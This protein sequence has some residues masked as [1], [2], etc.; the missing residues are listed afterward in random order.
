LIGIGPMKL[1]RPLRKWKRK[2]TE[3]K[4]KKAESDKALAVLKENENELYFNNIIL[5]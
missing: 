4:L 3:L 2:I 1:I 5:V